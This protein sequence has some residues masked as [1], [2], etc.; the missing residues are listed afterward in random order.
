MSK[1]TTLKSNI[2]IYNSASRVIRTC[3]FT[4]VE[5]ESFAL[6]HRLK[7]RKMERNCS[8]QRLVGGQCGQDPR[9]TKVQDLVPLL[10][11]NKD[12]SRHKS[13]LGLMTGSGVDTEVELILARSSIFSF[14]PIFLTW[15]F[16]PLI[17]LRWASGG[18]WVWRVAVY[19][20]SCRSTSANPV[21]RIV[22]SVRTSPDSLI[23]RI[24]GI[25]LPVGSGKC[26]TYHKSIDRSTTL[27]FILAKS[28]SKEQ[29]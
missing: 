24:T 15:I 9:S 23:L 1:K 16:V 19:Q 10:T 18:E 14:L 11:C 2:V 21:L 4:S 20:P 28:H 29:C 13:S 27:H 5:I 22:E 26:L 8:F 7:N 17:V 25:F 12:I 3:V 6:R